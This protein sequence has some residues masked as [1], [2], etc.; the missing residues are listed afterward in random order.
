MRQIMYEEVKS[1]LVEDISLPTYGSRPRFRLGENGPIVE[2]AGGTVR[3]ACI[4]EFNGSGTGPKTCNRPRDIIEG[5]CKGIGCNKAT[6]EATDDALRQINAE[7]EQS[8]TVSIR[9]FL[10]GIALDNADKAFRRPGRP[11]T[12]NSKK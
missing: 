9:S 3:F 12:S 2:K 7:D 11:T 10:V 1:H 4:G 5:T 6:I 8:G